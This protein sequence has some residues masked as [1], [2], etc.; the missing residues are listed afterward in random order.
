M[1]DG[2]VLPVLAVSDNVWLALIAAAGPIILA[3]MQ[4]RT[5]RQVK[6]A[7]DKIDELAKVAV[8]THTLVAQ[9]ANGHADPAP[10]AAAPQPEPAAPPA[11]RKRR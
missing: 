8:V 4:H 5:T 6:A 7:Q 10:E 2:T 1:P 11:K 9:V 3:Y